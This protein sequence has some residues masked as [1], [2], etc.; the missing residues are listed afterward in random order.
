MSNARFSILQ[1]RAVRDE[2]VSDPQFRTLAAL[3][4]YGDPDGWCFPS[5][6][7][8]KKDLHKSPQAISKDIAKLV[9]LEYLE[10]HPRFNKDGG[11]RSNLYR[12]KF[13]APPSTSEI[14]T[15]PTSEID[16]L[17]TPE[18]EVNDP[19][20]VPSNDPIKEGKPSRTKANDFP[21]NILFRE[22]T[23]R[24]PAKANWHDVLRFIDDVA[25]R[26]GRQPT[27]DDLF[28]FYS[29]W[30]GN[31]WR[32]DSIH[33]LEYA[34]RG[35]LPSAAN[36]RKPPENKTMNAVKEYLASIESYEVVNG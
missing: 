6:K 20:N 17:S 15:P 10:K 24:Y 2:R 9:E 34:A 27:K 33:W 29:A 4:C 13:D 28:P 1:A 16:T 14:D 7:T 22:V 8:L 32:S 3:G 26:I 31:G 18:V 25:R 23:E 5:L 35:V 36:N 21:S 11:R 19:I 30:C 12:L